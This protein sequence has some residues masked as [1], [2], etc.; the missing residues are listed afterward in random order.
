MFFKYTKQLVAALT[1]S[2]LVGVSAYGQE[3]AV[4][5]PSSAIDNSIL[6]NASENGYYAG[7]AYNYAGADWASTANATGSGRKNSSVLNG[8]FGF[9]F[10]SMF[11]S[12][13]AFWY[14]FGVS[15]A[16]VYGTKTKRGNISSYAFS[17]SLKMMLPL[18]NNLDFFLK[19]GVAYRVLNLDGNTGLLS[20]VLGAG[21][22]YA[23]N[24]NLSFNLGYSYFAGDGSV[25]D[26]GF[27][28]VP[29]YNMLTV[30]VNYNFVG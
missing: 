1:L 29:A 12:E 26:G 23:L 22:E 8:L 10:N 20:S 15:N 3:A 28:A 17:F 9:R 4:P 7:F 2:L 24:Q 30:G 19:G 21:L 16:L 5:A 6:A 18:Y 25:N 13:A 11:A 27:G 14:F